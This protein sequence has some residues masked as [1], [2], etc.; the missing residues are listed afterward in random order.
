MLS[1]LK[2]RLRLLRSR[3]KFTLGINLLIK[4][5]H[6]IK[7]IRERFHKQ[8][9]LNALVERNIE[10]TP[11]AWVQFIWN[12]ADGYFRP[13][14][15]RQE[16]LSLIE[17]IN[18]LKPQSILEIGTAKGGTLFLFC[19][20]AAPSATVVSIDL[21]GGINGGGY[22]TWKSALYQEFKRESQS[23]HFLRC[24]SHHESSRDQASSLSPNG[25]FDVIMI[26]GDHSYE[27]V[28]KDFALYRSLLSENGII[29][30]HDVIKNRFDPSIQVDRF[31][32][33]L[34][35]SYDTTEI[36][37]DRNQGN[38]GIGIVSP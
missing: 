37:F 8:A 35:R 18:T 25:K 2:H 4:L 36:V 16:M 22:P 24:D 33:E 26:D 15:Q 38:M 9:A 32:N 27:G 19:Q 17:R 23:L 20:A 29:V 11:E 13:I 31:W 34:K 12:A 1:N 3:G 30:F 6:A 21:P 28:K 5:H 10:D 7:S 14:Q